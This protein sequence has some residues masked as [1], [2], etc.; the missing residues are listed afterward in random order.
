MAKDSRITILEVLRKKYKRVNI[1]IVNNM[2]DLDA[3]VAKK[4]DLVVLGM[5]LVLLDPECGFDESRKI[6]L[7]D[8]LRKKGIAY[9]GSNSEAL[10]LE[11]EKQ[12]AK[13]V[14]IKAGL[15]SSR[16]FISPHASPVFASDLTF[17]L[18]VKP[19]NRG[20][21]K[22]VDEQSVVY[23]QEQ[24]ETK[25]KTIHRSFKSDALIE[26][27]LPGREFSVGV[28]RQAYTNELIAMPIEIS[29]PIDERGHSFLSKSIKDSDN[30]TV[31]EVTDP[32][33]RESLNTLAIEVFKA[34]GSRDYGRIDMRIDAN[35]KPSFMEANLM[36]GLSNHGY[37]SRCFAMNLNISYE[38]MILKIVSL[39]LE[40]AKELFLLSPPPSDIDLLST[41][42]DTVP[43][44]VS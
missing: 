16:Y 34:L 31:L 8:Y 19:T 25:V 36:P 1:S 6:W 20:D 26:E 43:T 35:G 41:A 29:S 44:I 32:N 24:L 30:E 21:S 13:Q 33:L 37:L 23:S 9:T 39:G 17:P 38:E 40:P 5:K 18:F 22:G 42:L 4:P 11:F 14:T 2:K 15:N 7:A 27:Y 28:I 12:E 3:L 10:S